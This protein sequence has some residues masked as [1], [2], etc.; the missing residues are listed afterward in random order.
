M[1]R[2]D[3]IVTEEEDR[4]QEEEHIRTA[5]HTCGYPDWGIKKVKEQM[6]RKKAIRKDKSKKDKA[7]EKSRGVVTVPYIHSFT[8]K[9]QLMFTKHRVAAVVKPQTTLTRQV[10]VHPKDKVDQE[11]KAGVVYKIPCNQCEKA[12]KQGDSWEPEH[13]K[14]AEKISARNFT[15]STRRAS[16]NEHHKSAI[17]DHVRQNNHIMNWGASEIVE[18]EIKAT[19]LRDGSRTAYVLDRTLLYYEQGRGSP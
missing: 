4:K 1:E 11:K 13:R 2:S 17:T 10:L 5:L 7:Q 16:T 14:E 6:K 8:E 12:V 19:S 15:R 18:Q 9:I 3:S